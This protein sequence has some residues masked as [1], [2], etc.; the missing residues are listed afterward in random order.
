V[1]NNQG[2]TLF[3]KRPLY[4]DERARRKPATQERKDEEREKHLNYVKL[5]KRLENT[6]T[7]R[8]EKKRYICISYVSSVYDIVEG[9]K[10]R[11]I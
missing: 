11:N 3:S 10:E 5:E 8:K 1:I 6:L 4:I 9:R 7:R 2:L